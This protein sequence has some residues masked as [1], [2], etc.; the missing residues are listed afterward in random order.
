MDDGAVSRTCF[1]Y[2]EAEDHF[3]SMIFAAKE[4]ILLKECMKT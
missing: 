3:E 4:R 2:D 1:D